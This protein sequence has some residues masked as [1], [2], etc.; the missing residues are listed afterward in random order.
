[1]TRSTMQQA[2][3]VLY[4]TIYHQHWT[5]ICQDVYLYFSNNQRETW[6]WFSQ[7]NADH[8]QVA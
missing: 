6:I 4:L 8:F 7:T 2:Q 5:L 3:K 1:M